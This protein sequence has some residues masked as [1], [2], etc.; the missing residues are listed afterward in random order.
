MMAQHDVA[1]SDIFDN[2]RDI[3]G[4]EVFA[5]PE[6]IVEEVEKAR[7]HIGNKLLGAKAIMVSGGGIGRPVDEIALNKSLFDKHGVEVVGAIINKVQPDK[8][9]TISK[10]TRRGL[11]RHGVPLLGIIPV[12]SCLTANLMKGYV[13]LEGERIDHMEES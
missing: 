10:Y 4:L 12:H 11:A 3:A 8:I 5:N 9:D 13:T 6:G 1:Q 2:S 7:E